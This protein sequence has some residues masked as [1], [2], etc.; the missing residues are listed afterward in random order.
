[1]RF[2]NL[3]VNG[4]FSFG[5]GST[6]YATENAAIALNVQT[7]LL[8]WLNDFFADMGAGLDWNRLLGTPGTQAEIELSCKR[9][10]LQSEGVERVNSID[11]TVNNNRQL[12]LTINVDT[13]YTSDFTLALEGINP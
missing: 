11:A 7:R 1:M 8:S 12:S 2:R 9:I 3:D 6:S 5:R 4:D 10:I 13:I